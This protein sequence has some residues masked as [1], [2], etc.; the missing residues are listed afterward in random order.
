MPAKTDAQEVARL[1]IKHCS[2]HQVN[3]FVLS[4]KHRKLMDNKPPY[5]PSHLSVCVPVVNRCSSKGLRSSDGSKKSVAFETP[6]RKAIKPN[7]LDNPLRRTIRPS[8]ILKSKAVEVDNASNPVLKSCRRELLVERP[9]QEKPRPSDAFLLPKKCF[10]ETEEHPD[11]LRASRLPTYKPRLSDAFMND[12]LIPVSHSDFAKSGRFEVQD[13]HL[14]K[15][16][17]VKRPCVSHK[18][19]IRDPNAKV[20]VFSSDKEYLYQDGC[21]CNFCS[22]LRRYHGCALLFSTTD[23]TTAKGHGFFPK[24]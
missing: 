9:R 21:D 15:H 19:V 11:D 14:Y 10:S 24:L 17:S 20:K 23:F 2:C 5:N 7:R 22:L 18:T 6:L 12:H 16:S 1:L 4:S 8:D 13:G 3:I